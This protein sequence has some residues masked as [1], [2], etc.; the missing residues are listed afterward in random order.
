M[1][2]AIRISSLLAL[3]LAIPSLSAQVPAPGQA[4]D[5]QALRERFRT[6]RDQAV[7]AKFPA[8]MLARADELAKRGEA[9][10]KTDPKSAARYFRDARWQLPFLPAGLPQHVVRVFGESRMRHAGGVN[11][12]AYSPDGTRFVSASEDGTAKVWDLGNGRE[13]VTYR[14][15]VDQPGDP[16]KA[17]TNV[18]G[19][20]DVSYHPRKP[21]VATC[22]GNQ[23]HL[24][25]PE[26]GKAIKTVLTI[27]KSDKPLK[28]LAFSPDG[29]F[30]A[31]GGD[32]GILRII[33]SESGKATYTSPSRNTRL[34]KVSWS[35]NG[36]MVVVGDASMQV[37]VYA[38]KQANQLA[39]AVQGVDR[40]AVLGVAFTADSGSVL[41][42]GEDGKIH[43]TAG[44]KPDGTNAAN[45]ATKISPDYVGHNGAVTC[46][47]LVPPKGQLLV[48]GG[49]DRTVRVWDVAS[50]KQIRSF[51][52]HLGRITAVAARGD[53]GQLASGSEDGAIRV[54]DL[55]ATDEHRALTDATDSLWAVA[56][57]PDGKRVAAAGS[58]RSIRVYDP[59]TG[60]LEATLSGAKSPITTLAFF[61]DSD[62]LVAAGGDRV[63]VIWDVTKQKMLKELPGH[64]SAILSV[65]VSDDSK[66]IVSGGAVGDRTVRG[67]RPDG[68]RADWTYTARSAVCAVA[69][70]KG[71]KQ[72]AA[73]LADGSLVMLDISGKTPR[74]LSQSA[75]VAGVASIAFSPDGSRLASVGGDGILRVWS[76]GEKGELTQLVRF[77][78]QV[79][80]GSPETFAPLTGVAFSP[81]GRYVAAVGA[82]PVVRIW[83][84]ETKSEV[85]GLRG[86]SDWVTSVAFSPDGRSVASVAVDKDKT[87]RLFEL[88]SLDASATGGHAT[89]INAVAVSPDGKTLATAGTDE[90]IKLWDLN[91]GQLIGTLVGSSDDPLALAFLGNDA[92]VL[93]GRLKHQ[94][95]GRLHFWR[96]SPPA[97]SATVPTGE[98]FAV[99]AN[100]DGTKLAAWA[101]RQA[102]GTG[103]SLKNNAYEIYDAKG[104]LLITPALADNQRKVLAVS[105]S[106]DLAWAVAGDDQ[107]TVR[108]W[109]LAKKDRIGDDYPIHV[110]EIVDLGITPDKKSLVAVDSKGLIKIAN[111]ADQKNR[112]VVGSVVADPAGVR[113]L[114]VSPTGTTFVTVGHNGQ[115]KAWSLAPGDL[116]EPKPIRTWTLPVSVNGVAYT[117]NG[118]QVVT[119]NADGTAYVLDLPGGETN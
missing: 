25:D 112:E 17:G 39:M 43:L 21:I 52:G 30:L 29:R 71:G 109:D 96:I 69:I 15:H 93:G 53:G 111:I 77:D 85:R 61:P 89:A 3:F 63:V 100:R 49:A 86:H 28:T 37:S 87:L 80:A 23:V 20:A 65:A 104:N 92:L 50:K 27:E 90:T 75:H 62:R 26:T 76:V 68:D 9:A 55:N 12:L 72:V 31:I 54:W 8:E 107:G 81:D 105:F 98:V 7:K 106:A 94:V 36:N 48:S 82:D 116:K 67:Y 79:K 64:E 11:A 73:G 110:N 19:V 115:V 78:G 1:P 58:D 56:F 41:T 114:L 74:D 97:L 6:E 2:I 35:P 34:E 57:S 103:T 4:P 84:V 119:A 66:L 13:V 113:S 14:G 102:V 88:P 60:K 118:R 42:C 40:G 47:A 46:L 32:D 24:W 16:T 18:L 117:P 95:T 108:I 22:S 91:T 51:Q 45:T 33:D 70:R 59:T 101:S 83:D 44:P 5:A 10:L 38:P 99:M